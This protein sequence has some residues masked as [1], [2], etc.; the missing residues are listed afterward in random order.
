ML[1][2]RLQAGEQLTLPHP[3]PLPA[4]GRRCHELRI[5]DE[6]VTWRIVHRLDPDA[7]IIAEVFRKTTRTTP[8]RVIESCRRRLQVYDAHV[9]SAREDP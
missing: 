2:R 5:H 1:L 3:R 4:I 9:N 6:H 8:R 7:V